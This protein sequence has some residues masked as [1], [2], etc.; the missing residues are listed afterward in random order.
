MKNNI[1]VI[2]LGV[3]GKSLALNIIDKGYKVAGY[4]RSPEKTRKII[5]EN[6]PN[7]D[8]YEN[9]KD[10]VS[11]L[12]LPRKIILMVPAGKPVDDLIEKISQYLDSGDILMDCGNS[13]FEDTNRRYEQL[14]EKNIHFFGIGVSG[15]E[16]GALHGPCIMPSGDKKAYSQIKEILESIAA[17][18]GTDPCCTY[19]GEKGSGH[20]VKMVH[21][22]IEYAD[23]QLLA[24]TYLILKY[25]GNYS[26]K[27]ISDIF[28][29]WQNT[30]VKSYLVQITAS[31]L[32]E[33]DPQSGSDL[34]DMILDVAGN[35]GTGRWTSIESLKQ[36]FNASMLVT[37]YQARIMSGQNE[38]RTT[39]NTHFEN[40]PAKIDLQKIFEAYRLAK[41]LAF[42]QGF[43]LYKDASKK[44]GWNLNL[45][46]IASI[47]RAGC[48]IQAHLLQEIMDVCS[49]YNNSCETTA[50]M[51]D[52]CNVAYENTPHLL[53]A[54]KFKNRFTQDIQA[55]KYTTILSLQQ[56]LPTPLFTSALIFANQIR[57]PNL[58]AN[59]IQAQRDFFGAHTYI[60]T[61]T[62]VSEHHIWSENE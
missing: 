14:A 4:N 19:I 41:T 61:D 18:K 56:D 7:F 44:Y 30:E 21:N 46:N 58:G 10:F 62:G 53:L 11:S 50:K 38:L 13:F 36:E 28:I 59:I 9:I 32:K 8:G 31:I 23:M 16:K 20:Y 48:I 17:K 5:K 6:I 52:D 24:E 54:E 34:I 26:N 49:T 55:L 35:K 29:K 39:F 1:G 25:A 15:G 27:E 40:T 57:F 3:M 42:L 43:E 12:Q 45:Q 33:K 47:F 22:G 60:R 51:A 2:G 37:A